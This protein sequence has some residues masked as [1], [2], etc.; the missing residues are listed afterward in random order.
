[1]L[2]FSN[3]MY[4]ESESEFFT[5][6]LNKNDKRA[7]PDI[8]EELN[9][10]ILEEN[11]EKIKNLAYS[12][13]RNERRNQKIDRHEKIINTIMSILNSE[14]KVGDYANI[15]AIAEQIKD[16]VPTLCEKD[17]YSRPCAPLGAV[18]IAFNRLIDTGN[19]ALIHA[20]GQKFFKRIK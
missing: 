2:N 1:M 7:I 19:Y 13:V 12:I 8:A 18:A 10:A 14:M 11:S 20:Y 15:C 16:S 9:K 3:D 5:S 6:Y 4:L 17:K